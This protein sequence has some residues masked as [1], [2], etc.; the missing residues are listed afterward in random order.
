MS[1]SKTPL[2][3]YNQSLQQ[4]EIQPDAAQQFAIECL[5][6]L[7]DELLLQEAQSKDSSWVKKITSRFSRDNKEP[8]K[9]LY[10]WGGVGRGKTFLVDLFFNNLPVDN[11]IRM[12][13][14]H[15]MQMVHSK[16][17]NFKDVQNPLE[18][19]ANDIADKA[20]VICFD[21]FF[22]SDI[23]DA[24][25]LGGLLK[26]LFER[27]VTLVATSNVEPVK[28]YWDG[29]QREKFLPAIELIERYTRVENIDSG[30]DYRLQF[31][32]QAEIYHC[33]LDDDAEKMLQTNFEHLAP[34]E[35]HDSEVLI[36]E[37]RKIETVKAADGVVWFDFVAICDGPRGPADYIEIAR[38]F[39]TVLIA[40]VPVMDEN[41]NDQARR[42]MTMIDEFYDRNVKLILTAA[43]EPNKLYVGKRLADTFVRTVSRLNEMRSH[44]YLAQEHIP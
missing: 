2:A 24:M 18:Y 5:Q 4:G 7:Y 3:L 11:K 39:Q 14:H 17:R 19:V 27:G 40:N 43:A 15:F 36:I 41:K 13:F 22:V 30:V 42:F 26:A 23:T 35:G 10:F 25:L 12:H 37:E 28:L 34:E 29:L 6:A 32:D 1:N 9:G 20:V 16:L 33:P 38:C 44:D 8:V 31:L 21:E